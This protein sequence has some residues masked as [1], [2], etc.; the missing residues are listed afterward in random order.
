MMGRRLLPI[1]GTI[2]MI[3][4]RRC[5]LRPLSDSNLYLHVVTKPAVPF[6][7]MQSPGQ[8][9]SLAG[10]SGGN[11]GAISCAAQTSAGSSVRGLPPIVG[12]NQIEMLLVQ[13]TQR[14]LSSNSLNRPAPKVQGG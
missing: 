6:R 3:F 11:I 13:N 4:E 7:P 8:I 10:R 1:S 9:A 5:L 2:I 12:A 14:I